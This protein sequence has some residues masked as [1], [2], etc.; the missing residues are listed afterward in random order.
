MINGTHSLPQ[1]P[2]LKL[3]EIKMSPA[4]T[5]APV[6]S[7]LDTKEVEKEGGEEKKAEDTKD[8][9]E[10]IDKTA[11]PEPTEGDLEVGYKELL[12]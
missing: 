6:P 5:P 2:P 8:G 7:P 4:P 9:V 3:E 1:P 10:S 12:T 11:K